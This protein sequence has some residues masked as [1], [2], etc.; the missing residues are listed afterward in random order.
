MTNYTAEVIWKRGE[1]NF[2]DKRYSRKHILRFDGGLEIPASSSPHSVP[3]PLSD[4]SAVDPE[5]MFVAALANCHMLWF[6]A[7]A[8]REGFCVDSYVDN[9]SGSMHP[10]K[11]GK[12]FMVEAR[13]N[14]AVQF[15]GTNRPSREQIETMHHKA[16][17]E[18]YI[19]NSVL[20][21]I[22]C[23]PIILN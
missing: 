9:A 3:P 4:A 19:A 18:C 13:L 1:Q 5:E 12:L 14:P 2:L 20:T 7:I 10:N 11:K 22:V 21:E 8:A 15:S 16:H 23:S 6:L 17:E